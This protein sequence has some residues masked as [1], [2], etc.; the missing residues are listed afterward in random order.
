[1]DDEQ[2]RLRAL[3]QLL[4]TSSPVATTPSGRLF[5]QFEAE[6]QFTIL[7]IL[8]QLRKQLSDYLPLQIE[9]KIARSEQSLDPSDATVEALSNEFVNQSTLEEKFHRSTSK[10]RKFKFALRDKKR[11]SKI[12]QGFT[13]W[14]DRV[15]RNLELILLRV[16]L[17]GNPLGLRTLQSDDNAVVLGLSQKAGLQQ[18][19]KDKDS[20]KDM[21]LPRDAIVL[22]NEKLA[23]MGVAVLKSK[24]ARKLVEYQRFAP[25]DGKPHKTDVESMNQLAA[26]LK[27]ATRA[28]FRAFRCAGFFEDVGHNQWGI[29]FDIPS[30]V[31]TA[32]VFS[33]MDA[34]KTQKPT[35][36]ERFKLCHD[37]SSTLAAF[38]VVGWLHKSLR[39]DVILF[40]NHRTSNTT[41][42]S[43]KYEPSIFGFEYARPTA[44]ITSGYYD[45]I[46]ERNIYRHP[47]RQGKPQTTFQRIHDIYALGVL[48][49][50][51]GLWTPVKALIGTSGMSLE[52]DAIARRLSQHAEVNLPV[53]VGNRF[54]DV[55]M[56]CLSGDFGVEEDDKD[57][58]RLQEAFSKY[59]VDVLGSAAA[60]L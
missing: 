8:R 5:D 17:L 2:L 4:F 56:R 50:E 25:V 23:H 57:E 45:D 35:L 11:A 21:R 10:F 14:N 26:L 37:L 34:Y 30:G 12:V 60:N 46:P 6:W 28:E 3:Q 13:E 27:E 52:P 53:K 55:T 41:P 44:K 20:I 32:G 31:S 36:G 39:S 24:P 15:Q 58:T 42:E 18:I 54:R 49:L 51:I 47:L 43:T 33:L 1:M 48:L 59:V 38:H 16:K 9:Y 22:A 7:E 19:L 40:F 29:L